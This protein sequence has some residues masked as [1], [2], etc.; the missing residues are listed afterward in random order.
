MI[1]LGLTPL[2]E[3]RDDDAVKSFEK[4]LLVDKDDEMIYYNYAAA[5]YAGGLYQKADSSLKKV[6]R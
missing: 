6:L 5:L 4:A 3:G 2:T 1:C